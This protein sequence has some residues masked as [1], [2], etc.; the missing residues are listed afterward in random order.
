[1]KRKTAHTAIAALV[2]LAA[3]CVIMVKF[4]VLKPYEGNGVEFNIPAGADNAQLAEVF[5]GNLGDGFGRATYIL[6]RLQGGTPEGSYGHYAVKHEMTALQISRN[7]AKRRQ[8]PVRLTFNNMR[9]VEE[10]AARVGEKFETDSASFMAAA[11]SVFAARGFRPAEYQAALLP[12]TYEFWWTASPVD[13]ATKLADHRGSFW[14][15]ERRAKARALG[16][17]PVEVHTIASIVEEESN[18]AD[19]RPV[20]ARLYLNRVKRGMPLQSDPT[21]KF[22]ARDFKARRITG[23]LLRVDSPYNTYTHKGLPPGPIRIVEARTL[24]AVLNAPAHDYIYMCAREDFSGYHNFA[25]T[26]AEHNRNAAR[27]HRALDARG[28]GR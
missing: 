11:D 5:K 27:Y 26:L 15:D 17:T 13:I 10:L 18:K 14:N 1:M 22:A 21:L 9:F 3:A 2:I 28:I 23:A 16:L 8:T 19:E 24:D 6:W 7:V 20:I 25:V 12:D 4:V